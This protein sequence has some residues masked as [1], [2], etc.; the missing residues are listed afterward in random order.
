MSSAAHA[1]PET[2]TAPIRVALACS[3]L[4]RRNVLR[5]VLHEDGLVPVDE[6]RGE[7]AD[8]L[9]RAAGL[10]GRADLRSLRTSML[11]PDRRVIAV[12]PAVDPAT[13]R[14]ALQEGLRGCVLEIHARRA[15]APAVR[16]VALGQVVVPPDLFAAPPPAL[17]AREK[18]VLGLVVLGL[19]NAEI[20]AKLHL[21]ESTVKSHLSSAYAK[22]GVRNRR[23]A[24][25]T[26]LDPDSRL[27]LGVLA[28][29]PAGR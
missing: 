4:R 5:R 9:V 12:V 1:P 26:I 13:L 10:A 8:V 18:Q 17:S 2:A 28:I 21:A 27:G 19:A 11:D 15:L 3:D 25:A 16:T 14:A 7:P 20:A 22:I 23:Q 29:T 24:A 6:R